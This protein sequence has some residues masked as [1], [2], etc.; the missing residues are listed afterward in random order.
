MTDRKETVLTLKRQFDQ[1][2][3]AIQ[4]H[5][6]FTVGTLIEELKVYQP[7]MPVRII[8]HRILALAYSRKT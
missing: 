2:I 4:P 6:E 5:E 8:M 1:H 7:E 3:A